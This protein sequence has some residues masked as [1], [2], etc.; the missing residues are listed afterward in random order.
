MFVLALTLYLAG[1]ILA[2]GPRSSVLNWIGTIL[3]VLGLVMVAVVV[4]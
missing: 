2:G 4:L 3:A 1:I